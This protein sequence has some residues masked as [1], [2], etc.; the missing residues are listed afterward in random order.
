M[1]NILL[2]SEVMHHYITNIH[3]LFH[4]NIR[5]VVDINT[6]DL[7]VLT[8]VEYVKKNNIDHHQLRRLHPS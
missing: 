4:P 7:K 3:G 8:L 5:S 2:E 1:K 6:H